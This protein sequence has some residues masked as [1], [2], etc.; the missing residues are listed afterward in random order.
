MKYGL[1]LAALT[2][3][4]SANASQDRWHECKFELNA[5]GGVNGCISQIED[6]QCRIGSKYPATT[7][8]LDKD[9]GTLRDTKGRGCII[10][11]WAPHQQIQCDEGKTGSTGWT[12]ENG[13]LKHDGCKDFAACPVND[14]GEWNIYKYAIKDQL[15]CVVLNGEN[16]GEA[17]TPQRL[18]QSRPPQ[19][20]AATNALRGNILLARSPVPKIVTRPLHSLDQSP[21]AMSARKNRSMNVTS[22][23]IGNV[24]QHGHQMSL[25][26]RGSTNA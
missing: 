6:G 9:T 11:S 22:L 10:T 15:K 26:I 25:V 8:V 14:H 4:V 2:F 5:Q 7:F 23:V 21:V 19:S 13:E 24:N 20:C 12:I 16:K 3:G 17:A 1:V 18:G